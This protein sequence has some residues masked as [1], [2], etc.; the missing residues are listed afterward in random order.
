[1]Y[2]SKIKIIIIKKKQPCPFESFKKIEYGLIG[3]VI[4][5]N[6]EP[7]YYAFICGFQIAQKLTMLCKNLGSPNKR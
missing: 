4:Y 3:N 7:P 6:I 5:V 2:Y 1:M